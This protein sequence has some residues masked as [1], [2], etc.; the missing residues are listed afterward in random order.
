MLYDS[1]LKKFGKVTFHDGIKHNYLGMTFDYSMAGSVLISMLG[2]EKD[3]VKD[4]NLVFKHPGN[5]KASAASPAQNNIFEKGESELIDAE[6][7]AIFHSFSMRLAYLAKRVKPEISVPVSY[8]ATQVTTPNEGDWRKLDRV[9]RY[10]ENNLGSGITLHANIQDKTIKVTGYIDAAFGCHDDG[11]SHTG[12]IITIG[13]GPVFVRSVKQKIV[14]KSST[15][16]ELVALSDEAGTLLHVKECIVEQGYTVV[17]V[18][19]QDNQSTIA[20][21]NEDKHGSLRTKHINVRYFWLRERIKNHELE[22]KYVPTGLM[23]A[24]ILTKA[25]QGNLFQQFLFILYS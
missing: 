2:F 13:S 18:I 12:V 24:D 14:T 22:I 23:F 16:A 19:A 6:R 7:K 3:L 9:I 8:L 11:K 5:K 4:W 15:E 10:V 1:L 21:I 20:L 25:L 17:L